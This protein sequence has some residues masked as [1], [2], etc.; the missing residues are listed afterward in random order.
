[1]VE[2]LSPDLGTGKN[3]RDSNEKSASCREVSFCLPFRYDVT[4]L[5]ELLSQRLAE[6]LTVGPD[7]F[8][9]SQFMFTS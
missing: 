6:K 4:Y 2:R 5:R 1:M 8:L 9:D 7:L 3:E